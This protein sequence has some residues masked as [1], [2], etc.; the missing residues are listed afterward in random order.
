MKTAMTSSEWH[1]YFRQNR[2]DRLP[3]AW[4]E[5]VNLDPAVRAPVACSLARFQLGKSSDG[6]RLQRAAYRHVQRHGGGAEA[7]TIAL[8]IREE[9]DQARLLGQLLERLGAPPLRHHWS[10]WLF[11]H[12]RHWS[13]L[14]E[15]LSVLLMG[16]IVGLKYYSIVRNGT[17]D[18]VLQR[19][20]DQILHDE[21]FH[22]RFH[23]EYLHH[24]LTQHPRL[25]QRSVW[26]GLTAMFAVTN[27]IVA[28]DHQD[29]LVALGSSA[30]EFIDD[31]WRTFAAARQ[32]ICSGEAFVWSRA[33]G[34]G[35]PAAPALPSRTKFQLAWALG[36]RSWR[37]LLKTT[38]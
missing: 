25:F 8:L 15:R 10:D 6:A 19:V 22:V 29:A 35:E 11:R 38:T 20:C 31:S 4:D 9:Q 17:P 28:W 5:P 3:I 26:W 12:A 37:S 33:L 18:P 2:L 13:G 34:R 27:A 16:E 24:R 1:A 30:D 32:T 36:A 21:K 7:E 23:C 14:S